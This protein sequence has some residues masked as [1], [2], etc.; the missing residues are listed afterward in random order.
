MLPP[1]SSTAAAALAASPPKPLDG[2]GVS[3]PKSAVDTSLDG[4]WITRMATAGIAEVKPNS[5]G[6][7]VSMRVKFLDGKKAA[8][9]PEQTGHPT[10]PRAEIAAYHVDR[11]LGFGRTAAVVGRRFP[12]ADLRAALVAS[13]ADAAYLDRFDKRLVVHDGQI[14][15]AL[16][17]W[18][19]AALTE[20][21]PEPAYL[22][23][24]NSKDAIPEVFA[25]KLPERSDL[26][27]FD[28]LID[29]PDRYSG[30]N[31]LRLGGKDG[32]L[33]F[34]DQG[35]AFGKNRLKQK[36]TTR[37]RLEKVCRFRASTLAVLRAT[38]PTAKKE[39]RL[40]A[41]LAK[42]LARDP[43]APVLDGAQLAGIDERAS[44]LGVHIAACTARLQRATTLSAS[45]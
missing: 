15:G 35:A 24:L 36:L 42:S 1:V 11:L 4:G 39:D 44:I 41:Q 23:F 34:L 25:E 26:V 19:T 30:G 20:E 7:S 17:A 31:V 3:L 33:V 21:E 10:D 28:F 18:H 32:P 2:K 40:S 13:G 6:G 45:R 5:G 16:I 37:D 29:N 9:K 14:D 12:A 27:V 22:S 43:L 8:L 38:A